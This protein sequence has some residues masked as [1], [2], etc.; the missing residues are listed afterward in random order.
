[1]QRPLPAELGAPGAGRTV[2]DPQARHAE[3]FE[4]RRVPEVDPAG[5]RRLLGGREL[6]DRHHL[7]RRALARSHLVP[8]ST[9]VA[10][11]PVGARRASLPDP[12]TAPRA[13]AAF[14]PRLTPGAN[15]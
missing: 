1:E 8:R 14:A 12:T 9:S 10:P 6:I 13:E 2:G 15:G 3:A 7:A 11:L 4:R 5:Q